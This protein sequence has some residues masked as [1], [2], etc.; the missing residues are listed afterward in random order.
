[1]GQW[2]NASAVKSCWI[3]GDINLDILKWDQ[4]DY[5]IEAMVSMLKD[6]IDTENFQQLV[7]GPMRFW[8]NQVSSLIDHCWTN[9]PEILLNVKNISRAGSDHNVISMRIRIRGDGNQ[10]HEMLIRGF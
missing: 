5:D 1:M 6:N 10:S 2:K 3:I 9:S 8:P 4:P 7:V